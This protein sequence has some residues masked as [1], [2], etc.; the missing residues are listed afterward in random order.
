MALH[1][2]AVLALLRELRVGASS[3]GPLVVEGPPALAESLRRDLAQGARPGA[4]RG[5]SPKGAE[6]FVLVLAG[7]VGEQE[8]EQLKLAH[9]NG[10]PT[11]AVLAG[12]GLE[13][14][15]PYVLATDVVSVQP[16]A[17]FPVEELAAV[18]AGRLAEKGSALAARVPVLR[19]A[20][21]KQ[22]VDTFS[23]R[24]A[25]VGAA[26]FI[27]GADHPVLALGQ[28]RMVLR[29]AETHGVEIDRGRIPEIIGVIGAG[30]AWRGLARQALRYVPVAGFGVRATV[31][32]TGTRAIGEAA[33]RYFADRSPP[34]ASPKA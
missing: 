34:S 10:V 17:G 15:V 26:V 33:T 20:V 9:R 6:A 8:E 19:P 4:V 5:G 30:Y 7:S 2:G 3:E 29:L 32:Y 13:P 18:I 1:P 28:L 16:G 21:S 24:A 25:V 11:I 14:R 22:L 27:P 12:P 23:R 31:A